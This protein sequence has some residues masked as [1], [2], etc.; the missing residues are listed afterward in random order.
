M[1]KRLGPYGINRL[2]HWRRTR[3]LSRRELAERAGTHASTI[4]KLELGERRLSLEWMQKLARSLGIDPADLLP[5]ERVETKPPALVKATTR[6]HLL[7]VPLVYIDGEPYAA[8]PTEPGFGERVPAADR[9]VY[10]LAFLRSL[11][12]SPPELLLVTR[13]RGDAMAPAVSDKDLVVIDRGARLERAGLYAF[14]VG[15]EIEIRRAAV[16]PA[17]RRVELRAENP[18]YPGAVDVDP[19]KP[20]LLGRVVL[21][22]HAL[23]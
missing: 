2:E 8:L 1:A 20:D 7:G 22:S 10:S 11:T 4:Q 5:D 6:D 17:T 23:P 15:S 18:A 12:T 21:V 3:G 19:E 13:A 9:K 14:R 16:N